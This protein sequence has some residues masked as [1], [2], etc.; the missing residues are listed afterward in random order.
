MALVAWYKL[1][2][3]AKDSSKNMLDLT[4]EVGSVSFVSGKVDNAMR[5][6]AGERF[7]K[8]LTNNELDNLSIFSLAVW[9]KIVIS[10]SSNDSMIYS[11]GAETAFQLYFDG[12][13]NFVV[14]RFDDDVSGAP[15]F[16]SVA[17]SSL[18]PDPSVDLAMHSY[19][20][21]WDG[22]Y[23]RLYYDNV[24]VATSSDFSAF[25]PEQTVTQLWIGAAGT[26]S[27]TETDNAMIF[28]HVLT[29]DERTAL[30]NGTYYI[31]DGWIY[32]NEFS[33]G[34]INQTA[35]FRLRSGEIIL[36]DDSSD[37]ILNR[38]D[39]GQD[40]NIYNDYELV[41]RGLVENFFFTESKQI[42]IEF[43]DYSFYL[44]EDFVTYE[45]VNETASTI[46]TNLVNTYGDG[47]F[48]L[49]VTAT[50]RLYNKTWRAFSPM[51]I[52]QELALN[53]TYSF[54]VPPS[55]IFNFQPQS[56]NDLGVTLVDGTTIYERSFPQDNTKLKNVIVVIGKGATDTAGIKVIARDPASIEKYRKR[57]KRIEDTSIE[58]EDAA[59]ERAESE[60]NR[61]ANPLV[62]GSITTGRN[63]S[64]LAGSIIRI[65]LTQKNWTDKDF[66]IIEANHE[67]ETP[68][69]RLTLAEINILNSD[70]LADILFNQRLTAKNWEDDAIPLTSIERWFE[71]ISVDITI[72][73][74]IQSTVTSRDWNENE[75][76]DNI[77]W[78]AIPGGWT[79]IPTL[80][81][82]KM[83][84]TLVGL[85]RMR[86]LYVG[87]A[88]QAL[89]AA[90]SYIAL[91]TGTS[92]A[93]I[94][95]TALETEAYRQGMDSGY[96]RDGTPEASDEHQSSWSDSD[97][98][99]GSFTEIGIFDAA[100]GGD[101]IARVVPSSAFSKAAN[102][103]L[104][105]RALSTFLQT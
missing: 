77:D 85:N 70:Q 59:V 15:K 20:M 95:D 58:T 6:E 40:V 31:I 104:R 42:N 94:S 83:V 67:L 84:Q 99:S 62:I 32:A 26:G 90:N 71:S 96:P 14:A 57:V 80:D 72:S 19:V 21:T 8:I 29:S 4:T 12:A 25:V 13:S 89:D 79:V 86:D 49:N 2:E 98:I 69:T 64:Y 102:E 55:R 45:A 76:N 27:T 54:F 33:D 81:G 7:S 3:D 73:A 82:V 105:V 38:L 28:D 103:N 47:L 97:F 101:L 41:F 51:E 37:T 60:L 9:S 88:V 52:I 63:F 56:F 46:V 39:N 92:P 23:I 10:G 36:S 22:T 44:A 74:E 5:S 61:L 91:G 16:V 75:W 48:T 24:L 65:T 43:V 66:L 18:S 35:L 1:D 30:Y 53:E 17:Y 34:D 78:D 68:I 87:K 100:G 50:T 11:F 93:T